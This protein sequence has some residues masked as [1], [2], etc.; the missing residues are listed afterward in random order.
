M[1]T[2]TRG[3][4]AKESLEGGPRTARAPGREQEG[5]C[6]RSIVDALG[7]PSILTMR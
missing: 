7:M 5:K 2:K 3:R 6:Q 4:G 1:K